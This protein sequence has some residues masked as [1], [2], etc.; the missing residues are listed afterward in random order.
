MLNA[1]EVVCCVHFIHIRSTGA[2]HWP[3]KVRMDFPDRHRF[4]SQ[5]R[6]LSMLMV[7]RLQVG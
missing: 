6:M 3:E 2:Q 1:V 5:V 7:S 4:H